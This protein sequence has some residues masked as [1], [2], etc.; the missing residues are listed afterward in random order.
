MRTAVQ[1][2]DLHIQQLSLTDQLWLMEKLTQ[3]IREQIDPVFHG[4]NAN[5]Q[6]EREEIP[7]EEGMTLEPENFYLQPT[8]PLYQDMV[9]IRQQSKDGKVKLYTHEEVWGE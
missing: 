9:A 4:L 5:V 1:E 8:S 6:Q 2:L 7:G 3:H